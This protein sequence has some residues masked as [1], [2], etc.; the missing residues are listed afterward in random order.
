MYLYIYVHAN[1]LCSSDTEVDS[2][3]LAQITSY[4]IFFLFVL[5]RFAG[6]SCLV[7]TSSNQ[8]CVVCFVNQATTKNQ[9]NEI[10]G[11]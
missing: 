5:S 3:T 2:C 8:M 1:I 7:F 4:S 6:M 9:Q 11:I 10:K